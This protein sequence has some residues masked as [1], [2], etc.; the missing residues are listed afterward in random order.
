MT[1]NLTQLQLQAQQLCLDDVVVSVMDSH[2]CDRGLSPH[3]GNHIRYAMNSIQ[4]ISDESSAELALY[5]C[6]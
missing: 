4:F 2:S 3:Q 6:E 1:T 5:L